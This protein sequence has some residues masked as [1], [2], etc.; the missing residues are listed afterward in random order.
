MQPLLLVL[1]LA[2]LATPVR[3]L[4]QPRLDMP[5]NLE[6][7]FLHFYNLD[8]AEAI[9]WFQQE[10]EE[11]P[12]VARPYNHLAQAYLYRVLYRAGALETQL[13]SGNNPFLRRAGAEI[14]PAEK[15]EFFRCIDTVLSLTQSAL[16]KDPNDTDAMYSR[17]IAFGLRANYYFLVEKSWRSALSDATEARKLHNRVAELKPD[18]VDARL[19]QGAHDYVVG[20]LPTLY[21]LLGFLIGFRGDK[22]KGIRTLEEVSRNGTRVPY[23]AKVLLAAIYRREGKQMSPRAIPLLKELA[24]KFPANHLFRLELIQLYS[25]LGQEAEA[26]AV[27]AAM[28]AA[29]A[30]GKDAFP[31]MPAARLDYAKGNFNFWYRNY[32]EALKNLRSATQGAEDLDLHTSVLS[33]MRLGQVNDLL[34]NRDAARAAYQKAIALA[35][36]SEAAKESRGYLS[37]PFVRR[38]G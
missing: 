1:L 23:D 19:V 20:S 28:D 26:R 5:A 7:G 12:G 11:A 37:K 32:P 3:S 22:E 21:K 10:L 27:F 25:D 33:Y 30:S 18:F 35:P 36:A 14:S 6:K 2:V 17:G 9:R 29:L 4:A 24:D 13:V 8:Y 31:R 34:G 16:A 38:D 15:A